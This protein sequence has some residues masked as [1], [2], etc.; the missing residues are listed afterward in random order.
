MQRRFALLLALLL[1]L[2]CAALANSYGAPGGTYTLFADNPAY[3][4]Y[5]V[6]RHDYDAS[7]NIARLA[8]KNRYHMQLICAWN[9]EKNGRRQGWAITDTSTAALHQPGTPLADQLTLTCD[10]EQRFTIAYPGESY[11]FALGDRLE[12]DGVYLLES[13][14]VGGLSIYENLDGQMVARDDQ[15]MVVWNL[16]MRGALRLEDFNIEL[17]PRSVDEVLR[18][19]D[20]YA[21]LSDQPLTSVPFVDAQDKT[22]P[23][24][25]GPS[26]DTW[27]AANGKA[28]VSL[29]E[30]AGLRTFGQIAGWQ[31][32]EYE[33]SLRTHRV[34]YIHLDSGPLNALFVTQCRTTRDT[35]LTDDPGVSQ[36]R[37]L[38]IPAGTVLNV[39][40]R[41]GVSYGYVEASTGEQSIW[42]F[43]P[44][45]DLEAIVEEA[46]DAEAVRD[47]LTG[48]WRNHGGPLRCDFLDFNG[49]ADGYCDGYDLDWTRLP[50]SMRD[51]PSLVG[52]DMLSPAFS[53]PYAI[54]VC[55]PGR[56]RDDPLYALRVLDDEGKVVYQGLTL[57]ADGITLA[58]SEESGFFTRVEIGRPDPALTGTWALSEGDALLGALVY[59]DD[60]GHAAV[61]GTMS[62][63]LDENSAVSADVLGDIQQ[64]SWYAANGTLVVLDQQVD[65]AVEDGRLLVSQGASQGVYVP[66]TVL[67]GAP[68]EN[69]MRAIAGSYLMSEGGQQFP[70]DDFTLNADGTLISRQP[71]C[72]GTWFVTG[73]CPAE[74]YV[75]NDPPFALYVTLDTG[76]SIR[77]GC[78]FDVMGDAA[79]TED[80][81]SMLTFTN[82]EGSGGY[83]RQEA[84]DTEAMAE[85]AGNYEW[86]SGGD[87][88][89]RGEL[90]LHQEG[91]FYF[92][93]DGSDLVHGR[94]GLQ[95][96]D[97]NAY[98]LTLF[99]DQDASHDLLNDV[100]LL[101]AVFT[102][103]TADASASLTFTLDGETSVFQWVEAAGNG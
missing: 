103:A 59:M 57:W 63:P 36:Y 64:G 21:R 9:P 10:G 72:S 96:V 92:S 98:R 69:V 102:P 13:A 45:R 100:V 60:L 26:E 48:T 67:P 35:Y 99:V 77:L 97:G 54:E 81:V 46:P 15:R 44:L 12:E 88:L 47:A 34:G 19:N 14:E 58:T 2:P 27:R 75:W 22:L 94:W 83:V 37:Q 40:G 8:V 17:F 5:T 1:L 20:L 7:R 42:G 79:S 41:Y 6:F 70:S 80:Y 74:G 31:L 55:P 84:Y 101:D 3:E 52:W 86:V 71:A 4:S 49:N 68:D 53:G 30:L 61:C 11:T 43:V 29:R 85:L 25:S 33:V 62:A 90:R 32:I 65:A 82:G 28:S 18:L 39:M 38:D 73:F 51:D 76:Y 56:F 91:Y 89:P 24:Y 23:V 66:A 50:E 16:D 95:P 78:D 87:F 93:E